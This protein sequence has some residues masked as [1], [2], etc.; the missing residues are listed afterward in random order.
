MKINLK[1]KEG[2][3][4]RT[5]LL[6]VAA[7]IGFLF[8]QSCKEKKKKDDL[9]R[10]TSSTTRFAVDESFRPIV[11]EELYIFEALNPGMHPVITYVPENA[12]V[13][14]LLADSVRVLLI[15]RD[16]TS[17]EYKRSKAET[18]C[19]LSAVSLSMR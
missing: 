2:N 13:N 18:C 1:V 8:F 19:R 12:A 9:S 15:S 16:F 5:A 7:L 17:E 10:F 3:P 14:L 11:D 6:A 4:R